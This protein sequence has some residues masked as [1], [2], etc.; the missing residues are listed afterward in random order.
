MLL[1]AVSVDGC[2][3]SS[4]CVSQIA[5]GSRIKLMPNQKQNLGRPRPAR[6]R[7]IEAIVLQ[8]SAVEARE[9]SPT[10]PGPIR[11]GARSPGVPMGPG[12]GFALSLSCAVALCGV[13]LRCGALNQRG[14][15][16]HSGCLQDCCPNRPPAHKVQRDGPGFGIGRSSQKSL[17]RRA[18]GR[19]SPA[20]LGGELF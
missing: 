2:G 6:W 5:V 7:P 20:K 18:C 15:G 11:T 17:K 10:S 9:S 14:P 3:P 1:S 4:R 12:A 13:V 19:R 8:A 16:F